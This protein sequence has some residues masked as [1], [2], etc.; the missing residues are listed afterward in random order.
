MMICF[1]R[2]IPEVAGALVFDGAQVIFNPSYGS[3]GEWNDTMLRTRA[4]DNQVPLIFTHPLQ[5]LVIDA[6]GE[7]ILDIKDKEGIYYSE[8][9]VNSHKRKKLRQRRPQVFIDKLSREIPLPSDLEFDIPSIIEIQNEDEA[10]RKRKDFINALFGPEGFPFAKQPDDV[11]HAIK[12][13]DFEEMPN[14]KSI[15]RLT[16]EMD[17]GLNSIAYHFIPIR[18][19]KQAVIYHQGH[20]GK[21]SLGRKTISAF[22][23]KGYDVIGMSM[24]IKGMN[25]IPT[26]NLKRFGKMIISKHDW[27][28]YLTPKSGHPVR[29]FIDPVIGAVNYLEKF[30]FKR[31]VM[32]GISGG[33]WTTTIS[34]AI[35]PRIDRCY[36]IPGSHPNYLRVTK[37]GGKNSIGDYEQYAPDLYRVA[38]YLELYILGSYGKNRGQLQVLNEFDTCCFFGTGYTTYKD[39]V[40][41]RVADLGKGSYDVFLDS[42]HHEHK[43]SDRA[44]RVIFKDLNN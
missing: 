44:L 39:I 3:R 19:N 13:P 7:V 29:Y 37:V 10:L 1:E 43:I 26:V 25:S 35:D 4:R 27:F 23:E 14:L 16:I 42:S 21:F 2:Q 36:P 11:E 32:I 41:K 12:D 6:K 40:K 22:L 38:N 33:G 17:W 28:C 30:N 15:D 20:N 5:T 18:S 34:A 9:E 8:I 24:P 31:I